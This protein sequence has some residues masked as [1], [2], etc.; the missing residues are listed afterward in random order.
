[1]TCHSAVANALTN[2]G[3]TQTTYLFTPST[4]G[5]P[6]YPNTFSTVPA[7]SGNKPDVNY[8]SPD[9]R[10]PR[11]QSLD[12]TVDHHL[13]SDVTIS[14]SY[15]H[16]RGSNLP[17]FRDTNL[18]PANS[19]VN[20]VLDGQVVGSFPFYRGSRPNALFQRMI[21][22]EPAVESRYNAL[23]VAVDKRMSKGVL[24]NAN[25]TLSKSEDNGQNSTTF[26]GGNAAFD[27]LNYR[28]PSNTVDY[29]MVPSPTDRRHRFVGSMVYQPPY[30]WGIGISGIV[31][32][33]SGL[34]ITETI[35]GS[36]SSAVGAVITSSSNGTGGFNVAPWVGINT[37]RQPGRRTVD[38]RLEKEV[39]LMGRG[40]VQVLWEVF[41]VFNRRN[42]ATF[43][44]T[45][46]QLA[47]STYD[48]LA[49]LATVTVT[50]DPGY[51]VARS[52][53]TYFW[54]MRDM[55]VGAKFLW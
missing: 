7:G 55:Q 32:L 3:V 10:R 9:F 41:N 54:G 39:H 23:V 38:L 4:V 15:L 16:S 18:N 2:N 17:D 12:V 43:S 30:L 28:N 19:T 31:T 48:P 5:A 11:I 52:A 21:I 47:G 35:A 22:E 46:F 45:A 8:F 24:I 50:R 44:N 40:R 42:Y 13:S 36:L 26:F 25:Y 14:A 53:S 29:P 20:Y 6:Q 34:P 1:M 33:E 51:L 49:N 37:D 27:S